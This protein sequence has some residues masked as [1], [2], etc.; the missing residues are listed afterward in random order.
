MN[1][2]L[3]NAPATKLRILKLSGGTN[4]IKKL[5]SFGIY[6]G[7]VVEKISSYKKGPVIVKVFNSQ[8]AIGKGMAEKILVSEEK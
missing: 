2:T 4:F 7:S 1:K 3:F 8:I 6:E 5:A